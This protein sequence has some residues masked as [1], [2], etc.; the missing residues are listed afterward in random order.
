[1]IYLEKSVKYYQ[2]LLKTKFN[3]KNAI[4]NFLQSFIFG[5]L[6]GIIGQLLLEFYE[7]VLNLNFTMSSTLTSMSII[8]FSAILTAFG[9][10]DNVGQLGKC[11]LAIPISG[12]ANASVSAAME[13]HKEG[14]VLG[15]GA[16]TLKIASSVIVL[17]SCSA[18]IVAFVRYMLEWY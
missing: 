6:V 3:Y 15:I 18:L 17:G 11:G 12:F 13:Y 5:G 14:I 8:L 9:V 10:Y 7:K 16:N 2:E 4:K 1:M